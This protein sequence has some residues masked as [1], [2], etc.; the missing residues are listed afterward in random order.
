[1]S[2]ENPR[3]YD[4]FR[5]PEWLIDAWQAGINNW[6]RA[7]R[8]ELIKELQ[9]RMDKGAPVPGTWDFWNLGSIMAILGWKEVKRA[10]E[11]HRQTNGEE[12]DRE[13]SGG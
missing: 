3:K 2:E 6:S 4:P 5:E 8:S 9:S 12:D 11:S 13:P 7:S 10:S 1:M